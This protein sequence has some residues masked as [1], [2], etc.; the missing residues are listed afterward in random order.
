MKRSRFAKRAIARRKS[1]PASRPA[2]PAAV[3][4]VVSALIDREPNPEREQFE[5]ERV[6]SDPAVREQAINTLAFWRTL[7]SEGANRA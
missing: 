7:R 3:A 1:R 2:L 5:I 6:T 4:A